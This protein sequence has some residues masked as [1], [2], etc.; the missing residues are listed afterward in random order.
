MFLAWC[1]R[2]LRFDYCKIIDFFPPWIFSCEVSC[3]FSANFENV[4]REFL[5]FFFVE[6]L[7]DV[8]VGLIAWYFLLQDEILA[9]HFY[10]VFIFYENRK[11]AFGVVRNYSSLH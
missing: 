1:S 6:V 11:K 8:I 4:N 9:D 3:D 2:Y 5:Q 7:V 10:E